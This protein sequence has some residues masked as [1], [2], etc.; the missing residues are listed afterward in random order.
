MAAG[1][2][3]I[4]PRHV[5]TMQPMRGRFPDARPSAVRRGASGSIEKTHWASNTAANF[6]PTCQDAGGDRQAAGCPFSFDRKRVGK[7]CEMFARCRYYRIAPI[8][9]I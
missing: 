6:M 5:E 7:P 4:R 9:V 3:I 1:E 8:G 2:S